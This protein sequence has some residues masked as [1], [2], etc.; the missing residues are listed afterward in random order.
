VPF[1]CVIN[2]A[3]DVDSV[4]L[5][6][7]GCSSPFAPEEGEAT[8]SGSSVGILT[9]SYADPSGLGECIG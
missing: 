9:S 8:N 1:G 7:C 4:G 3:G 5:V 6:A 2:E